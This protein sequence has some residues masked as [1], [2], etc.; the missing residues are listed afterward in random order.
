MEMETGKQFDVTVVN[1]QLEK[2]ITDVD[3]IITEHITS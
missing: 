1:D 2:A 3:T